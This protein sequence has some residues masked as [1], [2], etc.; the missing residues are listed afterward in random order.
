[1]STDP[2]RAKVALKLIGALFRV[3]RS[4]ADRPRKERERLRTKHS[5]PVVKRFFSWCED[6]WPKLL[7]STPIYDGVRYARN[8][9]KGLRRFLSDGRLPIGRVGR[10]RGGRRTRGV[11][12]CRPLSRHRRC[13]IPRRSSVSSARSSN[14]ACGFPAHGSPSKLTP[15]LSSG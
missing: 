11:A 8:Q 4:I 6:E 5:A 15:S 7:E 14:R 13:L 10:W 3:E 1:M 12:V 2:D 9:N